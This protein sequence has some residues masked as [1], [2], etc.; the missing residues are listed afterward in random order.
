MA[1]WTGPPISN[2]RNRIVKDWR[3][4]NVNSRKQSENGRA[5]LLGERRHWK[6]CVIYAEDTGIPLVNVD[7]V[8]YTPNETVRFV[9]WK[10]SVNGSLEWRVAFLFRVD[11]KANTFKV[12]RIDVAPDIDD[13]SD[14]P[15]LPA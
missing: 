6:Y 2:P 4:G 3:Q 10:L 11:L 8:F 15:K 14:P 1:V 7:D 12:D 13:G 5:M 9:G